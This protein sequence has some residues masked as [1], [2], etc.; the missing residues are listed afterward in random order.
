VPE[1]VRVVAAVQRPYDGAR[2]RHFLGVPPMEP[3]EP[4]T[5]SRMAIPRVLVIEVRPDG[6]FLDRYE[7]SGGE[8]GDTWHES[9]DDAK[10]QAS[11]E[12]GENLGSWIDVPSSEEDAVSF[13]LRLAQASS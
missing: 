5:R 13:A 3:G 12:Y 8:V 9:I 4:D 6:V 1:R 11:A 2:S 10:A 7:E